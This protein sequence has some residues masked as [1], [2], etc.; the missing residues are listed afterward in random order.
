MKQKVRKEN[1]EEL[2]KQDRIEIVENAVR[3]GM[4]DETISKLTGLSVKEIAQIR[5]KYN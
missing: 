5:M 4:D 2:I 1:E 3:L